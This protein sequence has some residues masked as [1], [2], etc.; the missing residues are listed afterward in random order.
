MPW[1]SKIKYFK[2]EIWFGEKK[3]KLGAVSHKKNK[4][5][6]AVLQNRQIDLDTNRRKYKRKDVAELAALLDSR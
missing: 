3:K 2:K 1:W 6:K 5:R 4:E